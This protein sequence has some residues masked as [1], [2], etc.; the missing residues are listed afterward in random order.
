MRTCLRCRRRSLAWHT[1][2]A[3][4]NAGSAGT[5]SLPACP[6]RPWR[7]RLPLSCHPG[8]MPCRLLP[9]PRLG[10][11]GSAMSGSRA[12]HPSGAVHAEPVS[13]SVVAAMNAPAMSGMPFATARRPAVVL[14][15]VRGEHLCQRLQVH[16]CPHLRRG[17]SRCPPRHRNHSPALPCQKSKACPPVK[18]QAAQ[19]KRHP[20]WRFTGQALPPPAEEPCFPARRAGLSACPC[21]SRHPAHGEGAPAP[22]H[23]L[24]AWWCCTV[25]MRGALPKGG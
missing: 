11:C 25:A 19:R 1:G 20:A 24:P 8:R 16:L 23:C 15:A 22:P 21:S 12:C 10:G 18:R 13:P 4:G 6:A 7:G 9:P 3:A 2:T 5:A 17:R 14:W